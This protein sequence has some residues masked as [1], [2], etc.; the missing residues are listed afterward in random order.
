MR[1]KKV[2]MRN[3]IRD[4]LFSLSFLSCVLTVHQRQALAC[5]DIFETTS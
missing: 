1:E 4:K 3:R 5:A 2:Y